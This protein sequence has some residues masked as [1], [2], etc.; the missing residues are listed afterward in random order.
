MKNIF[1]IF[2][3]IQKEKQEHPELKKDL[4]TIDTGDVDM[5]RI[6]KVSL[7]KPNVKSQTVLMTATIDGEKQKARE[8][9]LGAWNRFWLS[10]DQE[11]YKMQLATKIFDNVLHKGQKENAEQEVQQ[12][13]GFRR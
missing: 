10:D 6:D 8:V 4:L 5:K 9:P 13:V 3:E 7:F 12:R 2:Y 1:G 11:K